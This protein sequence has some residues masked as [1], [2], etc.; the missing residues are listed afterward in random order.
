MFEYHGSKEI[1]NNLVKNHGD[2]EQEIYHEINIVVL[3]EVH[4]EAL[5]LTHLDLLSIL[6]SYLPQQADPI[7]QIE[8]G[9]T[10][11]LT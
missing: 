11:Y 10:Y 6:R 2:K 5:N 4:K 8:Y 9:P 1:I 7:L 3:A